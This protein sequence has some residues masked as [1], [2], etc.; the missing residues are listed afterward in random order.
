MGLLFRPKETFLLNA[1]TSPYTPHLNIVLTEPWKHKGSECVLLVNVTSIR[2]GIWHDP[3]CVLQK[4]EHPFITHNSYILYAKAH[5][6]N[7]NYLLK[8]IS[9]ERNNSQADV[10]E[11]LYKRICTGLINSDFT[12]DDC[13]DFFYEWQESC[14]ILA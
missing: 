11:L 7:V 6:A 4:G 2:D 10:S 9:L 3:A 1:T 13:L 14:K 12:E 5:L 8:I